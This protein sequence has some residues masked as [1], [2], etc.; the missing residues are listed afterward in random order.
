MYV[1]GINPTANEVVLGKEEDIFKKSLIAADINFIPFEKL[2]KPMRVQAKIRYS[3]VPAGANIS[4]EGDKKVKVEFLK[5]QRAI[6][7]GQSVVF[8]DGDI[9]IGGGIIETVQ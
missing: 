8:Y 2:E 6:T 3:A 4:M 1:I 7:E 9:L 5:G